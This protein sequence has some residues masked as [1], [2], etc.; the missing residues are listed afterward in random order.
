[1]NFPTQI[2]LTSLVVAAIIW[3][4]VEIDVKLPDIIEYILG[5][6]IIIAFVCS[7]ISALTIIWG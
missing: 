5:I 1:M 4:I 2:M 7:I 3:V 6:I